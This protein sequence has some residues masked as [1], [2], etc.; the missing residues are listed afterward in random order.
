MGAFTSACNQAFHYIIDSV[1]NILYAVLD[2]LINLIEPFVK[3]TVQRAEPIIVQ[4]DNK[5]ST[6]KYITA[7]TESKKINQEADKIKLSDNDKRKA[8]NFLDQ[9]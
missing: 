9:F 3:K 8:D 4:A 5:P 6:T 7:K 2:W 1:R